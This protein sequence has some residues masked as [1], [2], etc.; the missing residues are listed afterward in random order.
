MPVHAVQGRSSRAPSP[1]RPS[2]DPDHALP[3]VLSFH[4][5]RKKRKSV[6]NIT[7]TDGAQLSEFNFRFPKIQS[8]VMVGFNK[9]AFKPQIAAIKDKYY[10]MF[11][12]K[13][14][15]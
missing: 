1:A 5:R 15:S 9:N 14:K 6:L 12:N 10:E 8:H 11:R 13:T 3:F 4:F 2:F 7:T